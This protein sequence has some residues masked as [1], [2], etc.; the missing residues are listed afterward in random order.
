MKNALK[1]GI[2][3]GLSFV[4]YHN[5]S[6][7]GSS[8]LKTIITKSP[9][10]A[11]V[12]STIDKEIANFGSAV[13]CAILE[14][15]KFEKTILRGPD[16]RRGN[17]WKDLAADA[18]INGAILLTSGDFDD[19]QFARDAVL[20][21]KTCK[22]LLAKKL[23]AE[24]SLF[25]TDRETGLRCKARP[26]LVTTDHLIVDVKTT[27]SAHPDSF[28]RDVLKYHYHM[29]EAHYVD[30]SYATY[31]DGFAS[32]GFV[33]LCI[34]KT[35]PYACAV[36]RLDAA[37]VREG[38]NLRNMALT[39]YKQC[40]ETNIWNGYEEG[41]HELRIPSFGFNTFDLDEFDAAM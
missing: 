27:Q 10:H 20:A 24:R 15:E 37:T 26:D 30:G 16:N 4:E 7:V 8:T 18:E 11:K 3:D 1:N 17:A 5:D 35:P 39:K 28:R 14:P 31:D 38:L 19:V 36:Y 29:Q 22:E 32:Q 34:E 6:A 2:H 13:H 12:K 40:L 33:F 23:V 9:A 21:N 41:I 25:W